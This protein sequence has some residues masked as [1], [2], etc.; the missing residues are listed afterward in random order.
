MGPSKITIHYSGGVI[1]EFLLMKRRGKSISTD[2]LTR[3]SE[4]Y[5]PARE[6]SLSFSVR[7]IGFEK[8]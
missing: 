6:D 2:S 1:L 7:E 8:L 5:I 3:L 4:M